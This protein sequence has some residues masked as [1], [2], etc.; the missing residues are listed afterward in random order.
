M[1]RGIKANPDAH[2]S[3]LEFETRVAEVATSAHTLT[4]PGVFYVNTHEKEKECIINPPPGFKHSLQRRSETSTVG[5]AQ[6]N[7]I[8]GKA[9]TSL[10]KRKAEAPG[11]TTRP[12]A[13]ISEW[14][15]AGR[16][17]GDEVMPIAEARRA[18]KE[19]F[20][21]S[22]G[23]EHWSWCWH[24]ITLQ[25]VVG[26]DMLVRLNALFHWKKRMSLVTHMTA[27]MA[28]LECCEKRNVKVD[29]IIHGEINSPCAYWVPLENW[30][31]ETIYLKPHRVEYIA[32]LFGRECPPEDLK[33]FPQLAVAGDEQAE[34]RGQIHLMIALDNWR[35]MPVR[36]PCKLTS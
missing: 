7:A 22:I 6:P 11:D 12:E 20:E 25:H 9:A 18:R 10:D 14:K 23:L 15:S 31:G 26:S 34:R 27:R 32:M 30:R 33:Q 17:P 24:T 8:Q 13:F 29:A 28:G 4:K 19:Q 3:T 36:Q 1:L 16:P 21:Q 2:H 5:A 35:W